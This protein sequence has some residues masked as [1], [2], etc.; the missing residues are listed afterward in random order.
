M[1]NER[2]IEHGENA[3][4]NCL[5]CKCGNGSFSCQ[6]V[7][8]PQLS[9]PPDEQI[10]EH[11]VCC[12]FCPGDKKIFAAVNT[13]NYTNHIKIQNLNIEKVDSSTSWHIESH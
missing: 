13:T 9:C 11:G 7:Q 12:K 2:D 6:Q 5:N 4:V 3:M 10:E 1:A 8:C